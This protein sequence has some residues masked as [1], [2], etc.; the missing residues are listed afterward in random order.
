MICKTLKS[1]LETGWA[2]FGIRLLHR[3]IALM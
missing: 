1:V 2:G 3:L